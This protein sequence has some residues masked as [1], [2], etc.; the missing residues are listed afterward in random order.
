MVIFAD[1]LYALSVL[2]CKTCRAL[3]IG[4]IHNRQE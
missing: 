1:N 4:E 3:G 2:M